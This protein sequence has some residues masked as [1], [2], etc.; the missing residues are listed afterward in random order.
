VQRVASARTGAE[1]ASDWLL[2]GFVEGE[3]VTQ[4]NRS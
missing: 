2:G 3:Q 4:L 1:S